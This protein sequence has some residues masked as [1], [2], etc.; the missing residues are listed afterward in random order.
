MARH[1]AWVLAAVLLSAPALANDGQA[2]AQRDREPRESRQDSNR[3]KWWLNPDSRKEL[4][5]SEE[6]SRQI[7]GIFESSMPPQREM[8]REEQKLEPELSKILKEGAADVATVTA[9][10][11]HLEKLRADRQALRTVMIYRISL[12]LTPEQ[13]TKLEA[14]R[15]RREENQRRSPD[16]RH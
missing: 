12:V 1:F 2:E 7:D 11:Q 6:Q 15:K 14:F 10:V 13:R 5:I 8:W 16:R 3:W 9:K 4:G